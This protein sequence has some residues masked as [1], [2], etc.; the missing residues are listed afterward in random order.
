MLWLCMLRDTRWRLRQ[1]EVEQNNEREGKRQLNELIKMQWLS[2]KFLK[3]LIRGG[4]L[5]N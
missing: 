1:V 5:V 4:K 2:E 3:R